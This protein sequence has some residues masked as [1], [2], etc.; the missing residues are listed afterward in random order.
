M[1]ENTKTGEDLIEKVEQDVAEATEETKESGFDPKAFMSEETEEVEA[2]E[3][4]EVQEEKNHWI[5]IHNN[6]KGL[7]TVLSKC[8]TPEELALMYQPITDSW[9][10][11]DHNT[12]ARKEI[13]G[14]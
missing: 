14:I 12:Q 10:W 2:K 4:E 7:Y 6:I 1:S 13:W 8:N 3:A 11:N 5:E 9:E